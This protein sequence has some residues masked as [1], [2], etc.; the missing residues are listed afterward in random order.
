[1]SATF[2]FSLRNPT[3]I[4]N[5]SSNSD[6]SFLYSAVSVVSQHYSKMYTHHTQRGPGRDF[7]RVR[8]WRRL[9][10]FVSI[11]RGNTTRNARR[12]IV[13]AV[14]LRLPTV[15]YPFGAHFI[16]SI[17]RRVELKL[18][19]FALKSCKTFRLFTGEMVWPRREN[20]KTDAVY[21]VFSR[22]LYENRIEFSDFATFP[23][24]RYSLFA[25]VIV[26]V[27]YNVVLCFKGD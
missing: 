1:M 8:V 22:C 26:R 16:G 2:F 3:F 23:R 4:I 7:Q 15:V 21:I 9:F 11:R 27:R 25:G 5:S 24:T 10:D 17:G 6:Y 20:P 19:N 12:R 14:V 18:L 13:F